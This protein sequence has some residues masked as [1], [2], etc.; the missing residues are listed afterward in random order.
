MLS[1]HQLR[2]NTKAAAYIV[3]VDRV[4]CDWPMACWVVTTPPPPP[5]RQPDACEN[6]TLPERYLRAVINN[7]DSDKQYMQLLLNEVNFGT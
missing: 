3:L 7:S 2:V 4:T 6:I 5:P 1:L